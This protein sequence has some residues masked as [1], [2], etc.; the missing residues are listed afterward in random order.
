MRWPCDR[1]PGASIRAAGPAAGSLVRG[2]KLMNGSSVSCACWPGRSR[3]TPNGAHDDAGAGARG[4][5]PHTAVLSHQAHD[6]PPAIALLDVA[7]GERR[8]FG[9]PQT[10]TQEHRQEGSADGRAASRFPDSAGRLAAGHG[11]VQ[12]GGALF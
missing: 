1:G 4:D 11:A 9:P 7:H 8:D 3:R 5:R 12:L 2:S 10:A 6:A